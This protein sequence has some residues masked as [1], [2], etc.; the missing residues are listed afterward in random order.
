M[1]DLVA[2][3]VG[4]SASFFFKAV[5]FFFLLVSLNVIRNYPVV[6]ESTIVSKF[7]AAHF[8]KCRKSNWLISHIFQCRIH[9]QSFEH[10]ASVY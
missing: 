8:S 4:A 5:L 1:P 10:H 7:A 6:K 3:G 9:P 2:V